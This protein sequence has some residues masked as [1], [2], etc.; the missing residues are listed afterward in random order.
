MPLQDL[1]E[2]SRWA[3]SQDPPIWMHLDG[4]RRWEA[5]AAGC[6]SLKEYAACF[7]SVSL[8]FTKGVGAP[9]GSIIVGSKPF[10][11]RCRLWR[12]VLGGG[13]RAAG[14]VAAPARVSV[15]QVFLR[16][17]LHAAQITAKKIAQR[18]ERIP[19]RRI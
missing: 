15:E 8:C 11:K 12:K 5:V 2:I 10:I 18:W 19:P 4:A 17:R 14:V 6:G 16:G 3:L 1:Q 7:H 13:I 9:I